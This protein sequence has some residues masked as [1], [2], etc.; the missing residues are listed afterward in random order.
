MISSVLFVS[1]LV[2]I[3]SAECE[4]TVLNDLTG[5]YLGAQSN[6][7]PAVI[8]SLA[9]NFT[10][11]EQLQKAN[12]TAGILSTALNINQYRYILDQVLCS[13][14]TE[15]VATEPPS[16]VIGTRIEIDGLNIT[17][18]DTL[19][20]T[21]GDYNFNATG[22]AYYSSLESWDPIPDEQQ[23]GRDTILATADAYLDFLSNSSI[24]VP[25]GT[26]CA[27][28]DG[29][30]YYTGTSNMTANTCKLCVP[31]KAQA[32]NRRYTVDAVFGAANIL[33]QY[34][35][36]NASKPGIGSYTFRVEAGRIRYIHTLSTGIG[37][38]DCSTS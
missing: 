36:A 23:D 10:Y 35:G 32:M 20:T 28:L 5:E 15:L 22:Y 13:T 21:R 1:I 8:G 6:G 12:F 14:A 29:S 24:S 11:T 9:E 31:I 27:R 19:I 17:E 25:W 4:R 18:I 7:N 37:Q 38:T 16:Y 30:G 2:G 26:P 33:F 34:R 3:A